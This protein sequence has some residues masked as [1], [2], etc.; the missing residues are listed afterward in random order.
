MARCRAAQSQHIV[1]V[2]LIMLDYHTRQTRTATVYAYEN[3]SNNLLS[4]QK[5]YKILKSLHYKIF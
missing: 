5:I 1:V 2:K 4:T 3:T